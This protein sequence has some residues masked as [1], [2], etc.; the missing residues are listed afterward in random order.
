MIKVIFTLGFLLLA[1]TGAGQQDERPEGSHDKNSGDHA[2]HGHD[3][4]AGHGHDDN[5]GDGDDEGGGL[6][7]SPEMAEKIGL[8]LEKAR[9][10]TISTTVVFPAE[11]KLNRDRMAAVS[12]RYSSIVQK[13][14]VEIGDVVRKGDVLATLE[15]HA[16]L[17]VYSVAT[18]LDGVVVSKTTSEGEAVG[19]NMALFEVA[20]LSTVWADISIFPRFQ[21]S[22][23][24][25]M[26]VEFIAHDGHVAHGYVKYISPLL[27]RESRTFTARCVLKDHAEDFSPGA[28]VRARITTH[29]TQV[30]VRVER[31]A[32]QMVDGE[33]LVF[34]PS[35]HG[36]ESRTVQL[37]ASEEHYIEI[38][39]G[40]D[41]GELYVAKGAFSFKAEMITSGMDPHAGH[42]H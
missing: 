33:H 11:I 38:T 14:F 9:G 41:P 17:A 19:D 42:G 12:P 18:P 39:G 23:R 30:P 5:T 13:V 31:E 8:E 37:G 7:I 24:K 28:F 40:L 34:V 3:D 15:N 4:H 26:P 1:V 10:G 16:T 27:S 2:G 20:D 35:E 6:N 22:I 29:S 32:V 25:D 36:F 21:H